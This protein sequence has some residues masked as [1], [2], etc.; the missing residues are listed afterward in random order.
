M[1]CDAVAAITMFFAAYAPAQ[2][3]AALIQVAE[4]S[5]PAPASLYA[6]PMF[7]D[8]AARAANLRRQVQD[9]RAGLDEGGMDPLPGFDAFREDIKSLSV[10]DQAG[11][12]ELVRRNLD[13]DLK[14][15]L[16][17][18]SQDLS[19]KLAEIEAASTV[20]QRARALQDMDYLLRDNLQV[21]KEPDVQSG[22]DA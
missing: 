19:V 10:K 20:E 21:I 2:H 8:I 12:D 5:A 16:H 22:L 1:S 9:Y 15:I 17:G 7:T 18:M 14:C 6:E 13:H 11:S 4:V 3:P